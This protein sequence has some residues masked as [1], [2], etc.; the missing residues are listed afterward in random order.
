[1]VYHYE[2]HEYMPF[3]TDSKSDNVVLANGQHMDIK[4]DK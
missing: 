2:T 4:N 1:M 3:N